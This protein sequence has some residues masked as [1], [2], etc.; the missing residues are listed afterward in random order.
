MKQIDGGIT[1]VTGVR[2]A[3][4]RAGIK[5][6]DAKDVASLL[7]MPRRLPPE[8]SQKIASPP[9][10]FWYAVNIL[11]MDAHKPLSS[12]AGTPTLALA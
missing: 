10:P 6:T 9:R 3:G 7:P 4:V 2:A 12:I 11:V 5:A 1:A 8:F